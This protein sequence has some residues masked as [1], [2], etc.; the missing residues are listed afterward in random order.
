MSNKIEIPYGNGHDIVIVVK[1]DGQPV[2]ITGWKVLFSA[3]RLDGFNVIEKTITVHTNPTEG[4]TAIA[5]DAS[6]TQIT[7]GVYFYDI[8]TV[9][10][11]GNPDNSPEYVLQI[12][13][14]R[15]ER[16]S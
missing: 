10:A 3:G 14:V 5:I 7:P 4:E 12:M 13:P 2:D 16:I 11:D 6:E 1:R 9:D 8:K 15:T